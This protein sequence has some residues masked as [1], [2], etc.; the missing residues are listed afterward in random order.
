MT[1]PSRAASAASH[2]RRGPPAV[3]A[4][5]RRARTL[6]RR[7]VRAPRSTATSTRVTRS[8]FAFR[9]G[10][11]PAEATPEKARALQPADVGVPH[12]HHG[13]R[14]RS[15]CWRRPRRRRA[16]GRSATRTRAPGRAPAG[17][18]PRDVGG[19]LAGVERVALRRSDLPGTGRAAR[20]AVERRSSARP[21]SGR[22]PGSR[23]AD[24]QIAVAEDGMDERLVVRRI[25][26]TAPRARCA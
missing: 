3:P 9:P 13:R 7:S 16:D 6:A 15:S 26:V 5:I 22:A 2:S 24:G 4:R 10:A 14:D 8:D 21:R 17:A 25:R 12:A 18:E 20:Y 1:T 23:R 19:A 11:R